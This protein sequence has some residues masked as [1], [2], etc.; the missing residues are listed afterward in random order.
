MIIDLDPTTGAT[1]EKVRTAAMHVRHALDAWALPS[2][3]KTSGKSGLHL[4]VP[5]VRGPTQTE[6]HAVARDVAHAIATQHPRVFTTEYRVAKRP[7][8]LVLL[9]HNQNSAGHTMAG[10]YSV[11]PT[12]TATVSTP[13]DWDELEAG[14]TPGDFTI[15]TVARRLAARADPWRAASRDKHRIDL[16]AWRERMLGVRNRRRRAG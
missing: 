5:I 9:D 11:R 2:F 14:A 1:F 10:P 15:A 12:P 13:L 3:I 16:E 8:G 7:R 6:V 4:F